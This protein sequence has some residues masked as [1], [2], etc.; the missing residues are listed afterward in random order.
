MNDPIDRTRPARPALGGA[1]GSAPALL[2]V[3]CAVLFATAL[4]AVAT[5]TQFESSARR[6]S[7]V[8]RLRAE[9]I[10]RIAP[11][12][13]RRTPPPVESSL[14]PESSESMAISSGERLSDAVAATARRDAGELLVVGEAAGV[15]LA[16]LAGSLLALAIC[17]LVAAILL[18]GL[19]RDGVGKKAFGCAAAFFGVAAAA[20]GFTAGQGIAN[21]GV[22]VFLGGG[23]A[24]VAAALVLL[25]EAEA[26]R[27]VRREE[28]RAQAAGV[29]EF[30]RVRPRPHAQGWRPSWSR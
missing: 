8:A 2:V 29:L 13:H 23:M 27:E 3:P 22:V 9:F 18:W 24:A 10:R 19:A 11:P 17:A 26:R 7:E 20:I 4:G 12:A 14:P 1:I 6:E 21:P 16:L 15:R 28:P 30:E 5:W 25:P